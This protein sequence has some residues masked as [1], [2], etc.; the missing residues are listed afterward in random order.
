MAARGRAERVV[1]LWSRDAPVDER[2]SVGLHLEQLR[3][4]VQSEEQAARTTRSRAQLPVDVADVGA[5][6]DGHIDA[7]LAQRLDELADDRCVGRPVGYRGAV[8]VEDDRL[9]PARERIVRQ[10]Y[11]RSFTTWVVEPG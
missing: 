10:G 3:S 9:E 4:P 7:L 2:R 1:L 8:P 11:D 5:T 6:H